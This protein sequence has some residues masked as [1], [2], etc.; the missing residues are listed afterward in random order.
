MCS[1]ADE[2]CSTESRTEEGS[3]EGLCVDVFLLLCCSCLVLSGFL[4]VEEN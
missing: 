1:H 3:T 4:Q 2:E